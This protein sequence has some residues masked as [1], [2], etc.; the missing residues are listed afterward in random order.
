M[1]T[2]PN[3]YGNKSRRDI[4]FVK[5]VVKKAYRLRDGRRV[6]RYNSLCVEATCFLTVAKLSEVEI[7]AL[8]PAISPDTA[9]LRDSVHNDAVTFFLVR[10]FQAHHD[11]HQ[12][13]HLNRPICPGPLRLNHCLWEY[14]KTPSPRRSVPQEWTVDQKHAY[15]GL[16]FPQNVIN[17]VNMS[18][19]FIRGGLETGNNWLE[20]VTLI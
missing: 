7:P 17:K 2:Y 14:A 12:R 1:Y 15:Y 6:E 13:D 9:E 3:L 11:S 19:C 18:P 10:W 8:D 5:G 20:S 16:I 4:F